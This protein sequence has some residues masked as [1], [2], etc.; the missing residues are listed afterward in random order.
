MKI[1]K[2]LGVGLGAIALLSIGLYFS[3]YGG[4]LAFRAFLAY[5]QPASEF[6]HSHAVAEPD[7]SDAINWAALPEKMIRQI[8]CQMGVRRSCSGRAAG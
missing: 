1:A 5:S 6:D 7:Y 4:D 2:R 8:W 3:G